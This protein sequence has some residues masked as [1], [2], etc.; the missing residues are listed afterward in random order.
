MYYNEENGDLM[1]LSTYIYVAKLPIN[2]RKT[3]FGFI[4]HLEEICASPFY[5]MMY[6][7][8]NMQLHYSC[9]ELQLGHRFVYTLS[10][11]TPN[12]LL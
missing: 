1:E 7:L 12:V 9:H 6:L 8:M 4:F 10:I 2:S 11:A 3:I 5:Q